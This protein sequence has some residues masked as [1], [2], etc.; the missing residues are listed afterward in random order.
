MNRDSSD[1]HCVDISSV[2]EW[3]L[4]WQSAWSLGTV[5]QNPGSVQSSPESSSHQFFMHPI[6]LSS[7]CRELL[8]P[9]RDG[10]GPSA[11]ISY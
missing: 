8:S 11:V 1:E 3:M 6:I 2:G 4:V 5:P 10:Y 7:H 9:A